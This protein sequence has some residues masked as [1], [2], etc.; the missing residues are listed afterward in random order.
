MTHTEKYIQKQDEFI[1]FLL[2]LIRDYKFAIP[3]FEIKAMEI[4]DSKLSA[5]KQE[6]EA[7]EGNHHCNHDWVSGCDGKIYCNI[8]GCNEV[9]EIEKKV[10]FAKEFR[11]QFKEVKPKISDIE[12]YLQNGFTIAGKTFYSKESVL[13]A[14]KLSRAEIKVKPKMSDNEILQWIQKTH[15]IADCELSFKDWNT[16]DIV[17]FISD[18]QEFHSQ[19]EGEKAIDAVKLLLEKIEYYAKQGDNYAIETIDIEMLKNALK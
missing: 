18:F 13:L 8:K 16:L 14:E 2:K 9:R 11:D 3:K 19:F 17:N 6:V 7:E 5:L 15:E 4:F 1:K 10:D 12:K